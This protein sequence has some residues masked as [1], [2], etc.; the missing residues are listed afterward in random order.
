MELPNEKF[1]TNTCFVSNQHKT[2]AKMIFFLFYFF[3]KFL[4]LHNINELGTSSLPLLVR[5]YT[6]RRTAA[7]CHSAE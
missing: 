5:Y 3:I 1:L 4:C 7:N 2:F 6:L